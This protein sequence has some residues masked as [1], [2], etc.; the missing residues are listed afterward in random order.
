MSVAQDGMLT[1]YL[2]NRILI[3]VPE[4]NGY[5]SSDTFEEDQRLDKEMV[6]RWLAEADSVIIFVCAGSTI[7]TICPSKEH[8]QGYSILGCRRSLPC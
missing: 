3:Y 6:E 5:G 2:I 1:L 7:L 8:V 4:K